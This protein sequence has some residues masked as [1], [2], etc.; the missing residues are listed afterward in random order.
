MESTQPMVMTPLTPSQ[1]ETEQ[2]GFLKEILEQPHLF[3]QLYTTWNHIVPHPSPQLEST[4]TLLIGLGEGSSYNALMLAK[5]FIESALKRPF[6]VYN[7]HQFFYKTD[8]FANRQT[9]ITVVSQS[10]QTDS[11]RQALNKA[12]TQHPS[13]HTRLSWQLI[14]CASNTVKSLIESSA[15][16][17]TIHI[18]VTEE[19]SIPATKSMTSSFLTLIQTVLSQHQNGIQAIPQF[20]TDLTHTIKDVDT[21]LSTLAHHEGFKALSEKLTQTT[22]LFFCGDGP[23]DSALNELSLKVSE[24]TGIPCWGFN[25]ESF[26]HGPKAMLYPYAHPYQSNPTLLGFLSPY[27]ATD[28]PLIHQLPWIKEQT[29]GFLSFYP[30]DHPEGP[31]FPRIIQLPSASSSLSQ[32]ILCLITGQYLSYQ[33]ALHL[34][35][36][37]NHPALKKTVLTP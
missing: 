20:L 32:I 11:I 26:R 17:Q 36:S 1:I 15:D 34:N 21:L 23:L 19:Q 7:P 29:V 10:G 16:F 3:Q 9:H 22:A 4:E 2:A 25:F 35:I 24:V 31:D 6:L 8:W 33:L 28:I 18:P 12:Q 13:P 37:P 27:G 14:T 5:P 30:A